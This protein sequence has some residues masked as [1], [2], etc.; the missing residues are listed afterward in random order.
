MKEKIQAK[1]PPETVGKP[2]ISTIVGTPPYPDGTHFQT[3]QT[4]MFDPVLNGGNGG[5]NSMN[6][7][8]G[9]VNG[10]MADGVG[11]ENI[12]TFDNSM[13]IDSM[14]DAWFTQQLSDLNWLDFY[15]VPQL[16]NE[17]AMKA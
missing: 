14:N 16:G 15:Q 11:I 12:S 10:G 2:S 5:M 8:N 13:Q 3:P 1:K 9:G 6:G 17:C 4:P 7:M